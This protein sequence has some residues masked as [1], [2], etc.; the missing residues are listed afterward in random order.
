MA[1]YHAFRLGQGARGSRASAPP[2]SADAAGE[3]HTPGHDLV[4]AA[5]QKA[6]HLE[7]PPPP[8]PA[9]RG[10]GRRRRPR[11]RRPARAATPRRDG[12]GLGA[13]QALDRG[14][15]GL[16]RKRGSRPDRRP[17]RGTARPASQD[18]GAARRGRGEDEGAGPRPE[19]ARPAEE[20]DD[21]GRPAPRGPA[22]LQHE[23]V[24]AV[25]LARLPL[26]LHRPRV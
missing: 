19:A 22:R 26:A 12:R 14:G 9:C 23:V 7:R 25:D 8:S 3:R 1:T 18:L 15:A 13:G 20:R 11:C 6:Q 10:S 21:L 16:S 4:G 5:G 24:R 17:P 2:P